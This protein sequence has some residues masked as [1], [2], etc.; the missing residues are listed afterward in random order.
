MSYHHPTE[1]AWTPV[2]PRFI[3]F[4]FSGGK[5]NIRDSEVTDPWGQTVMR[6]AST[7]RESTLRNGQGNVI[8]VIEWDHSVPRVMF[9]GE[10]RKSKDMF[11]LDRKHMTRGMTH[12]GQHYIWKN[13]PQPHEA[14]VGLYSSSSPDHCIAYWHNEDPQIFLDA[15]P[16][17]YKSGMLDI[18]LLAAFMMNCGTAIDEGGHGG[19]NVG[20]VGFL[21]T[22]INAA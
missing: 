17:V 15:A 1:A 13:M 21:S 12:Q 7:K 8:A 6:I 2:D 18:A 4:K 20:L 5:P 3:P 10:E 14:L 19:G 22:L 16:E 9:H 11:P